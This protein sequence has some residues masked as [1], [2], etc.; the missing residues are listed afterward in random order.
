MRVI[1][2]VDARV[3][4]AIGASTMISIGTAAAGLRA[5]RAAARAG[6]GLALASSTSAPAEGARGAKT[7]VAASPRLATSA[8]AG[9]RASP[10]TSRASPLAAISIWAPVC[11]T[12]GD[13]RALCLEALSCSET[14]AGAE[15]MA[16]GPL[17]ASWLTLVWRAGACHAG[18]CHA[19][20]VSGVSG[21]SVSG[22]GTLSAISTG[23]AKTGSRARSAVSAALTRV[24]RRRA[25]CTAEGSALR[26]A[27]CS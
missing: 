14:R 20:V 3:R 24:R 7:S 1:S 10:R 9:A 13:C 4:T 19:G 12:A 21:D 23:W 18:A 15:T 22:A 27:A 8:G 6:S 16:G 5:A 26:A 25:V 11:T 17:W 2:G